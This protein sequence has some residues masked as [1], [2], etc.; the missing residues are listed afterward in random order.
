M[1]A[2]RDAPL[3][4]RRAALLALASAPLFP[5]ACTRRDPRP[6][7]RAELRSWVVAGRGRHLY[8]DLFIT[9][10][11]SE[12]VEARPLRVEFGSTAQ[13]TDYRAP[14]DFAKAGRI[15]RMTP[16]VILQPIFGEPDNRAEAEYW[17]TEAQVKQL[18][19]DRVFALPYVLVGR[20]SN[21]AMARAM[22][23]AGLALPARV[24]RGGGLLGEFPGID[25]D[26]GPEIPQE[27]W[28]AFGILRRR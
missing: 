24:A 6:R 27:K 20:N 15:S 3:F 2:R 12:G 8:L 23:E 26:P 7:V 28:A 14:D 13:R 17:L 4:T 1:P 21:S 5:M 11:P 25:L 18:T 16:G 22:R 10:A 9:P 19:R